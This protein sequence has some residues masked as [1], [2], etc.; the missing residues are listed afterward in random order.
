MKRLLTDKKARHITLMCSLLYFFSYLTR[1]N[2]GAVLVEIVAREGISSELVAMSITGLFVTY[3]IGQIVSGILGDNFPPERVITVGLL[4]SSVMN[5]ILPFFTNPL[6][7]LGIWCINGF[8]QAMI[9]PPLVRILAS[10]L[11]SDDYKQGCFLV[12][13]ASSAGTICVYLLAPLCIALSGWRLMFR[14]CGGCALI[15]SV[16][17]TIFVKPENTA[18]KSVDAKEKLPADKPK[19]G[20]LY[21]AMLVLVMVAIAAQGAVRDGITTWMP[22]LMS[23]AFNMKTTTSILSGVVLP[24]FAIFSFRIATGVNRKLFPNDISAATFFFFFGA[25]TLLLMYLFGMDARILSVIMLMLTTGAMH[26][27][28]LMLISMLP[29]RFKSFGR[30]SFFTGMLNTCTY[31]GSAVS[32]FG[33]AVFKESFGWNNTVL[34]WAAIALVGGLCCFLGRRLFFKLTIDN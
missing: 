16:A 4:T 30:V 28:N 17:W 12:S 2:F 21:G 6:A 1:Y 10:E 31:V 22:T 27:V 29:Q 18:K 24:V 5:I 8:A 34:L 19:F 33:I 25:S 15:M 20:L 3:G 26:G 23:E 7:M 14:V 11:N 32:A 13:C 9:W